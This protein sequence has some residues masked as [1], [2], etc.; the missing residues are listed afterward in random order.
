M[1]FYIMLLFM[2]LFVLS[3]IITYIKHNTGLY[4][5]DMKEKVMTEIL[6]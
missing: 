3:L 4:V 6:Y 1:L 5:L 2:H